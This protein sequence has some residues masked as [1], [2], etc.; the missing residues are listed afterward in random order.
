M[1]L[2]PFELEK[3]IL[4]GGREG[5]RPEQQVQIQAGF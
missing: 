5:S 2:K 4:L 1:E 3:K